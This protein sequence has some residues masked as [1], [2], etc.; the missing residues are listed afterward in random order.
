[1]KILRG[2]GAQEEGQC[3]RRLGVLAGPVGLCAHRREARVTL[4]ICQVILTARQGLRDAV[5]EI[6]D[7]AESAEHGEID[8]GR[9]WTGVCA[10]EGRGK[11][12]MEVSV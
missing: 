11:D 8:E 9:D 6:E 3:F 10:G 12:D 2:E 5:L 1:M 7:E 4:L